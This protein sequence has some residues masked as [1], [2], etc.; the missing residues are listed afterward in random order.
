[1]KLTESTQSIQEAAELIRELNHQ[2]RQYHF[3]MYRVWALNPAIQF[4]KASYNDDRMKQISECEFSILHN[5][6]TCT[7]VEQVGVTSTFKL[8]QE[9]VNKLI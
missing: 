9:K 2:L 5:E 4:D 7:N 3:M 6:L 1:M 8:L